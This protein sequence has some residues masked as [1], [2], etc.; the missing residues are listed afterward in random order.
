[1]RDCHPC[2]TPACSW[3]S[4]WQRRPCLVGVSSSH[5]P[6]SFAAVEEVAR[7]QAPW[8]ASYAERQRTPRRPGARRAGE[9]RG[10]WRDAAM[11]SA[12]GGVACRRAPC[13]GCLSP[14]PSVSSIETGMVLALIL[15]KAPACVT[16]RDGMLYPRDGAMFRWYFM[17]L[18]SLSGI[19]RKSRSF[20]AIK[21][22]FPIGF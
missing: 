14:L 20:D 11:S 22:I 15:T 6:A 9:L 8:L 19:L 4:A 2:L 7:E 12:A 13:H 18:M 1:V 10:R 21:P 3:L 16:D 5:R 17:G